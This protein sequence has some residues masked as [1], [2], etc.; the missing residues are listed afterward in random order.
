MSSIDGHVVGFASS[1]ASLFLLAFVGESALIP[2]TVW[3][4]SYGIVK[5]S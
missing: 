5:D 2:Q 4:G 3:W 1:D